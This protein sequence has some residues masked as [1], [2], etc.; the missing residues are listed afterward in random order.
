[1][2]LAR[3]ISLGQVP[4]A[5]RDRIVGI[6]RTVPLLDGSLRRYVN[7]D[8]AANTQ[9]LQD[10]SDTVSRFMEWYS[11]VH[12]GAGFKSKIATQAYEDACAIVGEFV[13]ANSRDHVVLF[14]KNASEGINKLSHRL[15]LGPE[16]V[17]LVRPSST[18]ARQS[19]SRAYRGGFAGSAR[20]GAFR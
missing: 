1:M 2:N 4:L 7:L 6:D 14:G 8:N 5:F 10:V 16:N 12:R 19:A 9:A 15:P 11:S 13:G 17:V 3:E 20:R 18:T